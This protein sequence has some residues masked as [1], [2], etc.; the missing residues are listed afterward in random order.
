[1]RVLT[2]MRRHGYDAEFG[3]RP[4][5]QLDA[6]RW[7][8]WYVMWPTTRL[9]TLVAMTIL[10][11]RKPRTLAITPTQKGTQLSN[12]PV[13]V[14]QTKAWCS[15]VLSGRLSTRSSQNLASPGTGVNVCPRAG[16]CG[17]E[18][19]GRVATERLSSGTRAHQEIGRQTDVLRAGR[20]MHRL[21]LV[22]AGVLF[23]LLLL[24]SIGPLAAQP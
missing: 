4:Y 21:L 15:L 8:Y 3:G 24:Q 5:R 7:F 14:Q 23:V 17:I 16:I 11:N 1:V 9:E 12:T 19:L 20:S 13:D 2:Y 6:G 10:L 18:E 22:V